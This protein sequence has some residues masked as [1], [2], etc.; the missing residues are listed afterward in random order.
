INLASWDTIPLIKAH[1]ID[2]LEME[3]STSRKITLLVFLSSRGGNDSGLLLHRSNPAPGPRKKFRKIA[4]SLPD[5]I[6]T[7]NA[8]GIRIMMVAGGEEVPWVTVNK[9]LLTSR[10]LKRVEGM[11]RL[12]YFKYG[13]IGQRQVKSVFF[14]SGSTLSYTL[15]VPER[16]DKK[17]PVVIDG[18]WGSVES[19]PITLFRLLDLAIAHGGRI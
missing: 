10:K 9:L 11:P 19:K 2:L 4:I 18:Y 14:R 13:A 12:D 5:D 7:V 1:G 8:D 15:Q 16:K 6:E 17:T 3:L